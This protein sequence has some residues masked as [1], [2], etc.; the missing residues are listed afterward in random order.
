MGKYAVY[1]LHMIRSVK[2]AGPAWRTTEQIHARHFF[3][4]ACPCV[5]ANRCN[6]QHGACVREGLP[7]QLDRGE[8][9]A[10][11]HEARGV[12]VLLPI[13]LER[14]GIRRLDRFLLGDGRGSHPL[15]GRVLVT[16]ERCG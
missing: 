12:D 9:G 10:L 15:K 5:R 16:R 1:R 14:Q 2:F 3:E 4:Q 13:R 6:R 8:S 7:A 11:H